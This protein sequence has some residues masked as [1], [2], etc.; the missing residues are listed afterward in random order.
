MKGAD[1]GSFLVGSY[2]KSLHLWT[3]TLDAST[4]TPV[5]LWLGNTEGLRINSGTLSVPSVTRGISG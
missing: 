2:S 1:E 5:S 3:G 4:V